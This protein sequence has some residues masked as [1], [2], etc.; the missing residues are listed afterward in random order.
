MGVGSFAGGL[1]PGM[2]KVGLQVR[3]FDQTV[4]SK[5]L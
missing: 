1:I 2:K 4:S 3:K 5:M